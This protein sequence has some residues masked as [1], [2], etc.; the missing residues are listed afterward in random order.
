MVDS[1]ASEGLDSLDLLPGVSPRSPGMVDVD[2]R[3]LNDEQALIT[4]RLERVRIH[5]QLRPDQ[6]SCLVMTAQ[7]GTLFRA[8]AEGLLH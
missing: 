1:Q 6:I 2:L 4:T 8:S 3:R 7:L 5:L